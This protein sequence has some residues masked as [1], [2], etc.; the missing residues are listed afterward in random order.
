MRHITWFSASVLGI[1]FHK[2]KH[3]FGM[4][5]FSITPAWT[6]RASEI[7]IILFLLNSSLNNDHWSMGA[8]KSA[9]HTH[10]RNFSIFPW[11]T[12]L[13][14]NVPRNTFQQKSQVTFVLMSGKQFFLKSTKKKG[15]NLTAT[16]LTGA[17]FHQK[18]TNISWHSILVKVQYH[19]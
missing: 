8:C 14:D 2:N 15:W 4:R 11:I 7:E 1:F 16:D 12:L 10:T 5:T 19:K 17:R 6:A 13:K 18:Q 3:H 9:I